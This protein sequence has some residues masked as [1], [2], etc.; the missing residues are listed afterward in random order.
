MSKYLQ[1]AIDGP[2]AA[3][4]GT[5]ARMLAD[6]LGLI[7][8]DTGAM[9][10]AAALLAK[11]AGVSWDDDR[12]VA[13]LVE[14]AKIVLRQPQGVE[15]D[16]RLIS[17]IV[18]GRD[19]SWK[20]RDEEISWGSSVVA[21]LPSVRSV[22]VK[23]QKKIAEKNSVVMEGRDITTV[24]LPNADLKIFL[25]A[26]LEERA[27]RRYVQLLERGEKASYQ[28]LVSEM[29][30]R[31]KQDS[32]RDADPLTVSEEAWVLDT[33]N[34]TIAQVVSKIAVKIKKIVKSE[35]GKAGD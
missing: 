33:T 3:G 10:R 28:K 23:K 31:D 12:G 32:G 24:V 18:N 8:V 2:V 11:E 34:M 14:T 21:K 7:Y 30:N 6:Q 15:R 29:K 5:V 13:E 25:T 35:Y 20:I 9:Y 26:D 16:G 4:K 19:V 17:V 27:R 22:L 1:I